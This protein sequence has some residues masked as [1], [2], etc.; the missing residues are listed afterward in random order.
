MSVS[1]W[2]TRVLFVLLALCIPASAGVVEYKDLMNFLGSS[3]RVQGFEALGKQYSLG[4]G[5]AMYLPTPELSIGALRFDGSLQL[6]APGW[7]GAT[8][9]ELLAGRELSIV[10]AQPQQA[11]GFFLRDFPGF[12]CT[13]WVDLYVY[14]NHDLRTRF[15]VDLPNDGSTVFWGFISPLDWELFDK[16]V[17]IGFY[18]PIVEQTIYAA[19][20]PEPDSITML[21]LGLACVA[22]F[23][24]FYLMR[25]PAKSIN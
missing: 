10:F 11:F 24:R 7:A 5:N 23:V 19:P 14:Y 25:Q 6:D 8:R 18:S 15:G 12:G 13:C 17:L 2:R 1:I 22:G 20:T 9:Y 3:A 16:V 21:A 4:Y